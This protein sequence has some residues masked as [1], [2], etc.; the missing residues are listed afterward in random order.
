MFRG[1]GAKQF[2]GV[3]ISTCHPYEKSRSLFSGNQY[4]LGI[5]A[6]A[7]IAIIQ[8]PRGRQRRGTQWLGARQLRNVKETC[9]EPVQTRKNKAKRSFFEAA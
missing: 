5:E 4:A 8:R 6:P 2:L 3:M 1:G 9:I 7:M